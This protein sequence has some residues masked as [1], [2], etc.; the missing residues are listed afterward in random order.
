MSEL[1]VSGTGRVNAGRIRKLARVSGKEARP[2]TILVQYRDREAVTHGA[3]EKF[4]PVLVELEI[5]GAQGDAFFSRPVPV[6]GC[7]IKVF[8]VDASVTL[9]GQNLDPI[10]GIVAM[11]VVAVPGHMPEQYVSLG[12]YGTE[13][14]RIPDFATGWAGD[15][16]D[17][18]TNLDITAPDGSVLENQIK[19]RQL[20]AIP[21]LAHTI[22]G[23]GASDGAHLVVRVFG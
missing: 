4:A 11:R 7:A 15:G 23:D 1:G 12:V 22:A 8:C 16:F 20:V 21:E 6:V 9:R 3:L 19:P 18:A 17:S 13:P 5:E 14:V 2:W 10:A